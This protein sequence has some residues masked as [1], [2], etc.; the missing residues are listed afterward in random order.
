[1][2]LIFL[3]L[4][5]LALFAAVAVLAYK[6]YQNDTLSPFAFLFPLL[7]L[8]IMCGIVYTLSQ[9]VE[10]TLVR[11]A[12]GLCVILVAPSVRAWFSSNPHF[13][14]MV[15]DNEIIA[16]HWK[17]DLDLRV[18]KNRL[19]FFRGFAFGMFVVGMYF[20]TAF[21][22]SYT[23]E[24]LATSEPISFQGFICMPGPLCIILAF[25]LLILTNIVELFYTYDI[26]FHRNTPTTY[27][28]ANFCLQCVRSGGLAVAQTVG[29]GCGILEITSGTYLLEPTSL[30]NLW[31]I[32][33]PT[34]RGFGF[35]NQ[36]VHH[37]HVYLQSC[38]SY[39]PTTLVNKHGIITDGAQNAFIKT[40]GEEVYRNTTTFQRQ[41]TGMHPSVKGQIMSYFP[42]AK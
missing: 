23:P 29:I 14:Q 30:G 22:H 36:V 9:S 39:D 37:K 19:I 11:L 10:F 24:I 41:L 27:K 25:V 38:P 3:C 20:L 7:L 5:V 21:L 40:H 18:V 26:I 42:K 16:N 1:M 17:Q 4:L 15:K 2:Y 28:I 35:A 13:Q 32:Y 31:Q 34:G 8:A 12:Y 33:G 6:D